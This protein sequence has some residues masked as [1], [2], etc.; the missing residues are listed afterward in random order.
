MVESGWVQNCSDYLP[1]E[2]IVNDVSFKGSTISNNRFSGYTFTIRFTVKLPG[3]EFHYTLSRYVALPDPSR[4]T[5]A[6]RS[7][8]V[9][10]LD[11]YQIW[12]KRDILNY[13]KVLTN[14][15]SR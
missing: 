13:G 6:I 5:L 12:I 9:D 8:L 11:T 14:S 4:G 10:M 3:R 1:V 2:V 7:A 15:T